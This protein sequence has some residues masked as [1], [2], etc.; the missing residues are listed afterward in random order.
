MPDEEEK[1][2]GTKTQRYMT[3]PSVLE[4]VHDNTSDPQTPGVWAL[5]GHMRSPGSTLLTSLSRG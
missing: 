4:K 1:A 2:E 3:A 5:E